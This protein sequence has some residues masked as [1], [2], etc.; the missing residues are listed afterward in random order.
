MPALAA[1][2]HI[3]DILSAYD[4]LIENSQRRVK[5]LEA[6]A[7]GLYREWFVH[8]RFP[9]HENHSRVASALGEIPQGWETANPGDPHQVP[10]WR[11]MGQG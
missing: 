9:G 5:I 6:I 7:R 10:H 2:R 8:F 11:R 3:A 1:Q 4:D